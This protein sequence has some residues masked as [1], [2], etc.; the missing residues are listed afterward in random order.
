MATKLPFELAKASLGQGMSLIVVDHDGVQY[1]VKTSGDAA[2]YLA[3][4]W[5]GTLD[6]LG[7]RELVAYSPEVVI[8]TGEGRALVINDDLREENEV[9]EELLADGDRAQVKPSDVSGE[10][11]LYAVL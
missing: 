9:V 7:T 3:G 11:Y 2:E 10:L 5:G 8:R 4:A 6:E 1:E